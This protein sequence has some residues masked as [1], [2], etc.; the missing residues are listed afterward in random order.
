MEKFIPPRHMRIKQLAQREPTLLRTQSAPPET[1][2]QQ[3]PNRITTMSTNL[4]LPPPLDT[5]NKHTQATTSPTRPRHQVT[6]SISEFSAFPKLHRPHHHHHPPH[7][8][9]HHKDRE[10]VP[11]SAGPT[12]Q[13]TTSETTGTMSEAVTPNDSRDASRRTSVLGLGWE[14]GESNRERVA[15]EGQLNEEREKGEQRAM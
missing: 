9:R 5:S 15:R 10:N 14:D 1:H 11:Q 4:P 7:V 2:L 8:A 12:L 6:R 13:P 3:Y